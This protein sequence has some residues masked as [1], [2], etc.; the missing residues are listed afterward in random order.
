[1]Q[2]APLRSH[3]ISPAEA[4]AAYVGL[5]ERKDEYLGVVYDWS[6]LG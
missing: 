3:T 5:Q 1:L 2:V 6:R 4:P